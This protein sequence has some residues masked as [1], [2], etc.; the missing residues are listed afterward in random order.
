MANLDRGSGGNQSHDSDRGLQAVWRAIEEQRQSTQ[1]ITQQLEMI[2][3]QLRALLRVKRCRSDDVTQG[4]W[5]NL[6][7]P[8][9]DPIPKNQN[10]KRPVVDYK[11]ETNEEADLWLFLIELGEDEEEE[12]TNCVEWKRWYQSRFSLIDG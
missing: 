7:K 12:P 3:N 4:K 6:I 1:N 11:K 2:Q 5:V 10:Q 8:I 9:I